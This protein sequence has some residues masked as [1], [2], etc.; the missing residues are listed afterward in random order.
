MV[1]GNYANAGLNDGLVAFYPFNGNAD[2]ESGN[3]NHGTAHG[4]ILTTDRSGNIDSAYAFDGT[5][6][7]IEISDNAN[8]NFNQHKK[9]LT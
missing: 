1:F 9:Y 6:D 3:E 8:F 7:Y 2:D 5:N 4:A